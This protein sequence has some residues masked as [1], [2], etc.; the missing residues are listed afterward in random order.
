MQ[1]FD[2][3]VKSPVALPG[4]VTIGVDEI[5]IP[6]AVPFVSVAVI[7]TFEPSSTVGNVSV[8]LGVRLTIGFDCDPVK[9]IVGR[10][11][12]PGL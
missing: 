2:A 7:T 6:D 1:V 4:V 10:A 3:N 9:L 11:T 12:L 5:V 8:G